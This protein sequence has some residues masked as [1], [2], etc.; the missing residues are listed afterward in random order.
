MQVK[1]E[2]PESHSGM[3]K[4][5]ILN[6]RSLLDSE[7]VADLLVD[8]SVTTVLVVP[9]SGNLSQVFYF[10]KFCEFQSIRKN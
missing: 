6:L 9:Y 10:C 2:A 3:P 5:T 8:F 7:G 4:I 1:Q